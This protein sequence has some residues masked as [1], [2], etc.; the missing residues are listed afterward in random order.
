MSDNLQE[1]IY[2]PKDK[3]GWRKEYEKFIIERADVENGWAF[4]TG[5]YSNLLDEAVELLQYRE[6]NK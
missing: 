3:I 5:W 6:E 2:W 4:L 1:Y